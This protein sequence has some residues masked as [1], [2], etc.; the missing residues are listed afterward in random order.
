M[1]QIF[2]L[3]VCTRVLMNLWYVVMYTSVFIYC[4]FIKGITLKLLN[5]KL[6]IARILHGGLIHRQGN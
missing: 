5:N 2:V 1:A 6:V 3:L 4:F